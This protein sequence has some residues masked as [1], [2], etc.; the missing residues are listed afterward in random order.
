MKFNNINDN[1]IFQSKKMIKLFLFEFKF[2]PPKK[3]FHKKLITLN[4][5]QH[6]H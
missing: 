1:N 2:M 5:Y 4:Q 3:I 6:D